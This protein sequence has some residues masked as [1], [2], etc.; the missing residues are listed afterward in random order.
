MAGELVP[1]DFTHGYYEFKGQVSNEV[2]DLSDAGFNF[3]VSGAVDKTNGKFGNGLE[4][5]GI[6]DVA[7]S[8]QA[9]YSD[10]TDQLGICGW[11]QFL[12]AASG[13][14]VYIFKGSAGAAGQ[15]IALFSFNDTA[16]H[17]RINDGSDSGVIPNRLLVAPF[18]FVL[19]YD[20]VNATVHWDDPSINSSGAGQVGNIRSTLDL[21]LG[22]VADNTF[23]SKCRWDQLCI[24]N[25][26]FTADEMSFMYNEGAGRLLAAAA[27]GRQIIN[28]GMVGVQPINNGGVISV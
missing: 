5:D 4:F 14:N 6:N 19:N 21:A 2:V 26:P 15:D 9:R 25:T 7:V 11:I 28:G 13:S 12:R 24:K 22:A 8:A 16:G 18:F 10:F 20:G 27:A 17:Y 3:T 23:N 1:G